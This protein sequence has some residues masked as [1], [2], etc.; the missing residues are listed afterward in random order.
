MRKYLEDKK[1]YINPETGSIDTGEAWESDFNGRPD[2]EQDWFKWGGYSLEL[3]CMKD[4]IK[5]VYEDVELKEII[6]Q[7]CVNG[8]AGLHIYYVDTIKFHD[9]FEEE[10]WDLLYSQAEDQGMSSIELL[11]L[12]RG[13]KDIRSMD[14][15]KNLLC[16]FAIEETAREILEVE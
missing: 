5:Q 11:G 4:Y 2:K 3:V 9:E 1:Y 6:E 10:I 13:S 16:W 12:F 8:A 15:L 14:Q 7:G